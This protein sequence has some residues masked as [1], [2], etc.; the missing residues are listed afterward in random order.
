VGALLLTGLLLRD[1]VLFPSGVVQGLPLHGFEVPK[2]WNPRGALAAVCVPFGVCAALGLAATRELV[3]PLDLRAPYR[4]GA[5]QWRRGKAYKAWLVVLGLVVVGLCLL[6]VA[7]YV[8]PK[9]LHLPSLARKIVRRLAFTP[10]AL[11]AAIAGVQLV[12]WAFARLKTYRFMPLLLAGAAF[13]AYSAQ[14]YM[15]GL[16]E[17]FSPREVYSLY[18]QLG[19][20]GAVLAEY[21]VGGRAAPYYANGPVVEVTRVPQLV[22]HLTQQGQRWATFPKAELATI[23]H[24]YRKKSGK[25]LYVLDAQTERGLLAVSEP[26]SART[27]QNPLADAVRKSAPAAIQHSVNVSFDD[28]IELLGYTLR[29]PHDD[30]VG[31]GDTVTLTWYFRCTQKLATAYRVFV[32]IDGEGQRI[33]GDHDP[34]DNAY[35]VTLW[36]PGDIIVDEQR[37]EVPAS[38]HAGEYQLLMGFY[39]GDTRLPIR[40]GPNAGEDRARVGVLRIR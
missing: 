1:F 12:L 3:Q 36:E 21:R 4:F 19:A 7:A 25:H 38:S 34:V 35:P 17:Q 8:A 28:R 31:A 18:N 29:T 9:A 27:D 11:V 6:G 32:H 5:A 13:G 10:V 15:L 37:I 33:H 20:P 16:S 40:Q 22:E 39:S 30:Y 24:A 14:H 2:D 23:D 26:I